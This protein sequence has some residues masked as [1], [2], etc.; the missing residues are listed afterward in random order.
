MKHRYL[1]AA[2][3]FFWLL[4]AGCQSANDRALKERKLCFSGS[5]LSDTA[6]AEVVSQD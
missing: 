1:A 4:F 5:G 3:L 6:A 2:F